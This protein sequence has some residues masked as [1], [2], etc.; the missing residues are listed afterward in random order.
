MTLAEPTGDLRWVGKSIPRKE[1]VGKTTGE[2][3]FFS[4]MILPNML[5]AKVVRSKYPHALI[6]K[7]DT[8]KAESLPGVVT[9]L[10]HKDVPGLNGFGI[11]IPDQP[12]LCSD[13][14][15]FL[16]D[17]IAVI[18]AESEEIAEAAVQL[19]EID[20][21]PLPVVTDP[22]EAMNPETTRVHANG[23][24]LRHETVRNGNVLQA[25][26][27][28][29]VIVEH[30]YRTPRQMHMFLETEAGIGMLD[31]NGNVVLYVGGQAPYRDQ[32][33][34]SRALGIKSEKVRVISTPVGGAFGGKEEIT[35]QIHLALLAAKTKRPVKLVWTREESGITGIK[36]HPMIITTKTATDREGNLIA[37]QVRIIADTGAYASLGP[38]VLDVAVENSC[39]AYKIPNVD[40]DAYLVYTNNGVSG[41]FRGFGS[42]Q[43]NFALESNM[44]MIAEKL[45]IDRLELR[46]KNVLREGDIGPFGYAIRGSV[47]VYETLLK[48]ENSELWKNK[49]KYKTEKTA[50]WCKRGIGIATGV[51]GF[52][53]GALPDFAAASIQITPVGKFV[54]G[55]S[56]PEI[57]QGGITAYTQ[58]AAEALN[59]HIDDIYIASADSQLAPDTGT[60]SASMALVRGG[61]AILAAAP[62]MNQLLL[63]AGSQILQEP[64]DKLRIEQSHVKS[65]LNS[66]KIVTLA[67]IAQ[68]LEKNGSDTKVIGGFNV[69]R[70]EKPA[71]GS[72]E[73]PHWSYMYASG[74]ALVE[75]NTLT[76]ATKVLKFL[77]ATDC[78]KIIN[79]QSYS[80]QHE[81]AILQGIGFALMEDT[82]IENGNVLTNNFTA[83]IIPTIADMPDIQIEPVETY[84]KIGP[85]GAKG[86]GEIGIVAVPAAIAN[87]IY[88]ATG[89]RIY[90]LPAT[91]ERVY[92]AL[93]NKDEFHGS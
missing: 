25:F 14:V 37:N 6:R 19:V 49:L 61:N 87:A 55:I 11:V 53:F 92:K 73:I 36:R 64:S 52:G 60:T 32:M 38:T 79:P 29:A 82:L 7:I 27:N 18:A 8:S 89:A 83:Y 31:E 69:P 90:S 84:E 66:K 26:Q 62:K 86:L 46:K 54:I 39:G 70:F 44:D 12:V 56:C 45:G 47:G 93:Q 10:T 68:H 20:Y 57:G 28:A 74:I 23:N 65:N 33:Q 35:T 75:V 85:F 63:T 80:G 22:V 77:L 59:C 16:G 1:G 2:T 13:K 91:P 50:A 9:V 24:L 17:A 76:G 41:A 58:I 15:R 67:Q 21:E 81:G 88:D 72:I 42:V 43:V 34:V 30:T 3:K 71:E 4:D 5:W 78:G 51:K 40:I 48:V